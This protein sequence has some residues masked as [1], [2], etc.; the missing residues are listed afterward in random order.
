M[1]SSTIV[2]WMIGK[3]VHNKDMLAWNRFVSS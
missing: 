3:G 1:L 2:N